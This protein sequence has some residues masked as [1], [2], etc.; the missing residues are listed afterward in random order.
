MN[1]N[2]L[3]RRGVNVVNFTWVGLDG[4]VRAKALT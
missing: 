2:E 4:Y 1:V 3:K